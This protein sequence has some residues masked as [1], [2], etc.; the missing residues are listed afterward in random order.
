M[1]P[2]I[3]NPPDYEMRSVVRYLSA[4]DVN[5]VEIHRNISEVYGQNITSDGMVCK[6][7]RVFKDAAN[8][9]QDLITSFGWE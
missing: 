7:V 9:T 6:W 3:E 1:P 2:H 4:K 8:R 5:V